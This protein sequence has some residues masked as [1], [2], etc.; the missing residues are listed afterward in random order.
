[1]TKPTKGYGEKT[2]PFKTGGAWGFRDSK[3]N[4]LVNTMI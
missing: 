1:M 4:D 3:I 2:K